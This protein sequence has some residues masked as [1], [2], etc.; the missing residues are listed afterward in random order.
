MPSVA[1][2]SGEPLE[3]PRGSGEWLLAGHQRGAP[4]HAR[5]PKELVGRRTVGSADE[6]LEA[7]EALACLEG[8]EVGGGEG[9][10]HGVP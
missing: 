1:I 8:E 2:G 10:G 6:R 4:Q 9:I 7:I 3:A 5:G